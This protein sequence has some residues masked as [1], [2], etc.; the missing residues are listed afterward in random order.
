MEG[1]LFFQAAL[2]QATK[3]MSI[4]FKKSGIIAVALHPGWVFKEYISV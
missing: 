3:S 4:D 1:K 2:N